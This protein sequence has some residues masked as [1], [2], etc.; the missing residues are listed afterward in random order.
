MS[1]LKQT[2]SV[3]SPDHFRRAQQV[4]GPA[5]PDGPKTRVPSTYGAFKWERATD[6]LLE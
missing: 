4:R 5:N 6:Y 3:C 2:I 1:E